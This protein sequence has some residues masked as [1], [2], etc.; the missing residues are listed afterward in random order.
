MSGI[1]RT[2]VKPYTRVRGSAGR[3]IE[4]SSSIPLA[5]LNTP[6]AGADL[7]PLPGTYSQ[8]SLYSSNTL[9]SMA[10]MQNNNPAISTS[11]ETATATNSAAEEWIKIDFG[12]PVF[13]GSALVRSPNGNLAGGWGTTGY[14]NTAQIQSSLNDSTW[15][16]HG[17]LFSPG[18]GITVA[19]LPAYVLQPG[20]LTKVPVGITA[21]YMRVWRPGYVALLDFFCTAGF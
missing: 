7:V 13:I 11:A 17:K 20:L 18:T 12:T 10:N 8:S 3:L 16:L 6:I 21:R 5:W 1:R 2:L 9:A 15:T 14:L 19:D 4:A